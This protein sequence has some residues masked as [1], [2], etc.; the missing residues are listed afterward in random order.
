M[1]CTLKSFT[2]LPHWRNGVACAEDL[3]THIGVKTNRNTAIV[4][5]TTEA[6]SDVVAPYSHK[7]SPPFSLQRDAQPCRAPGKGRPVLY[8]ER[9]RSGGG[10][11]VSH[12]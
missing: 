11:G 5:I 1:A 9:D 4:A 8:Q 6:S 7:K 10:G 3:L 12:F 2:A